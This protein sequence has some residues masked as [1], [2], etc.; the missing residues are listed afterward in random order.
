MCSLRYLEIE[1]GGKSRTRE[2]L[3]SSSRH[4]RK[5]IRPR[6]LDSSNPEISGATS[7]GPCMSCLKKELV[8]T[9]HDAGACPSPSVNLSKL[10]R[11]R[12]FGTGL[13]FLEEAIKSHKQSVKLGLRNSI[14]APRLYRTRWF[15]AQNRSNTSGSSMS[16][17]A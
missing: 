1:E 2:T 10:R 8:Y 13:K 11:T 17:G 4:S 7:E 3:F 12:Y 16:S 9:S 5:S 15:K 6:F 14:T